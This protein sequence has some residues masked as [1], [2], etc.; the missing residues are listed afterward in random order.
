MRW[1][2]YFW[3]IEFLGKQFS[4]VFS[5]DLVGCGVV[6]WAC[7]F[8][9]QGW[10]GVILLH[11]CAIVTLRYMS[12]HAGLV[13]W[14][15]WAESRWGEPYT[16]ERLNFLANSFPSEFLWV[17]FWFR[18]WSGGT[19]PLT[20]EDALRPWGSGYM[21]VQFLM[22]FLAGTA[23]LGSVAGDGSR[24]CGSGNQGNLYQRMNR[25]LFFN[26]EVW[27]SDLQRNC[28]WF[29]TGVNFLGYP[30]WS[31]LKSTLFKTICRASRQWNTPTLLMRP[32]RTRS[33]LHGPA[34]NIITFLSALSVEF[35]PYK[36][37]LFFL[38]AGWL[39]RGKI[40]TSDPFARGTMPWCS[41]HQQWRSFR[42]GR[43]GGHQKNC[44]VD[45][46]SAL[47]IAIFQTIKHYT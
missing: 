5:F 29:F 45:S 38:A 12:W 22:H 25:S 9:P 34:F 32:C 41:Q 40:Y 20:L 23:L 19:I 46:T 39:H 14:R 4:L 24:G 18:L 15:R 1:Q 31:F 42:V 30:Y 13:W 3:T 11:V 27:G 33:D 7:W 10:S 16:F 2:L 17:P 8:W 43:G 35:P 44:S 28:L 21:P 26:L 47:F 37:K 6:G 36:H